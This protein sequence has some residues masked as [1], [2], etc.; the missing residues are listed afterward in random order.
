MSIFSKIF[1]SIFKTAPV[2]VVPVQA[3]PVAAPVSAPPADS[4]VVTPKV[5]LGDI[6]C[7][8]DY[9]KQIINDGFTLLNKVLSSAEYKNEFLAFEFVQANGMT[10]QQ[11]WDLMC[12]SSPIKMNADL[13]DLGWYSDHIDHTV[14]YDDS[15]DPETVYMNSY[16]VGTAYMVADNSLHEIMHKLGFSHI[17]PTDYTSVPYGQNTVLENTLAT[18]NINS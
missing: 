1:H 17:N 3:Q 11:I 12:S 16:F 4:G 7:A 15:S 9:Q 18:M 2:N 13:R 8:Y 6:S 14:G 10:N 5:I